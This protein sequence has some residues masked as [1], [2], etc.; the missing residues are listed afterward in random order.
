MSRLSLA[1]MVT[2]AALTLSPAPAHAQQAAHQELRTGMRVRVTTPSLARETGTVLGYQGDTL[3][4]LSGSADT[5]ALPLAT[6]TE[7]DVRVGTRRNWRH[8]ATHGSGL[9]GLIGAGLGAVVSFSDDSPG[10][11]SGA[12]IAGLATGAALGMVAGAILGGRTDDWRRVGSGSEVARA[13]VAPLVARS[14]MGLSF[15]VPFG[16]R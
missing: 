13:R 6:A 9:G 3:L 4:L 2:V 10:I 12:S 5:L 15:V 8:G 16:G 14:G 11:R 7:I 1:T